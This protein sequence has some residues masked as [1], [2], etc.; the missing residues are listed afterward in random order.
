MQHLRSSCAA[1]FNPELQ[2]RG[3]DRKKKTLKSIG[4]Q[5]R[6]REQAFYIVHCWLSNATSRTRAGKRKR[7][8]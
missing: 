5:K 4:P 8:Q 7:G 6:T 1:S 3:Y 2:S